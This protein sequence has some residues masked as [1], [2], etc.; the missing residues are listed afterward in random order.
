MK[1]GKE[2]GARR[3]VWILEDQLSTALPT[4]AGGPRKDTCLLFVESQARHST[5]RYH[6]KRIVFLLSAMRHFAAERANEGWSVRYFR[7]EKTPDYSHAWR[8]I[9]DETGVG[10]VLLVE[11]NNEPEERA[12]KALAK[13]FHLPLRILP[14]NLFLVG[15]EEFTSWAGGKKRLLMEAHYRRLREKTGLLMEPDGSPVGGKWNYDAEN[16]GGVKE[17]RKDGSPIPPAFPVFEPDAITREVMETVK[18][19]FP[20]HPGGTE[21]FAE[22][23]TRAHALVELDDFLQN[24]IG[25][26]GDYQDLM[27]A[28][29]PRMF[30]SRISPALNLGLLSPLECAQAAEAA[31]REGVAPLAA[32]EGFI[33]QIIGWREF[34]NGVYWLRGPEYAKSNALDARRP[35]PAFFYTGETP[36]R[37][38]AETLSESLESAYNHHIQ[39]LMVLG[40]FLL[41]AGVRPEEALR[42][43]SEMYLDAHDWVMAANVIGMALH[44]D[45]GYMATKPYAG[46][47]AYLSKMSDYCQTCAYSPSVKTGAGAC[48]FNVL[49]WAFIDRNARR[50]ANNPRMAMIVRSWLRRPATDRERIVREAEEF[51]DALP[52]P[53]PPVPNS[54]R[55]SV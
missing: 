12:A 8:T 28:G 40:N 24:R 7:V 49:Y 46:S 18:R 52:P 50:F 41:L 4:L 45:G 53:P 3:I 5:M 42:W 2:A 37:C 17:W 14:T 54:P 34:V 29:Q 26:F 51:L 23:V 13:K 36:L 39:R 25:R 9:L 38:L 19:L 44:A 27:I 6:K 48:P 15:R 11:P 35:L 22:A 47:G 1:K 21:G 30:H 43:F 32:A 31:F 16:R 20:E 10:E 55:H 33:R